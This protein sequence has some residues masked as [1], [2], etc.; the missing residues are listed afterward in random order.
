MT[1][2]WAGRMRHHSCCCPSFPLPIEAEAERTEVDAPRLSPD[3]NFF[4]SDFSFARLCPST[5]ESRWSRCGRCVKEKSANGSIRGEKMQLVNMSNRN[6]DENGMKC[7][8]G[9]FTEEEHF[10]STKRL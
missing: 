10:V 3:D 8:N 6:R 5:R 4:A 7:T 9:R 1:R 2:M